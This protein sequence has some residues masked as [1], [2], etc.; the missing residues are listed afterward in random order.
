MPCG[1]R[2]R[3]GFP[4]RLKNISEGLGESMSVGIAVGVAMAF[5]VLP[6][7]VVY[8]L[9][10]VRQRSFERDEKW[11][12]DNNLDAFRV[13]HPDAIQSG[14]FI[15]PNCEGRKIFVRRSDR[16]AD[17]REHVCGMCGKYLYSST[18]NSRA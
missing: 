15:C 1:I 4:R 11:F 7:V 10:G 13:R 16:S 14:R 3:L 17:L 12:A 5:L 2:N 8:L 18:S 9:R 6:F